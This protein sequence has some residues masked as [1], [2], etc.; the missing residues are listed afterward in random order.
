MPSRRL[1]TAHEWGVPAIPL[2]SLRRGMGSQQSA[3]QTLSYATAGAGSALAIAAATHLIAAAAVPFI[4]PAIAGAA[5]LAA[6]LIKNSGC[7]QTCIQTSEWANQAQAALK[8]NIDAY[9]A[10]PVPRSKENQQL[11]LQTFDSVWDTLV[12]MCG[13]PQWGDA[14]KAC[15]ADRQRGAC[16]WKATENSQWPGGVQLGEC[17]N[18]FAGFRDPIANDPNVGTAGASVS[19]LES[20]FTGGSGDSSSLLPALAIAGLLGLAVAL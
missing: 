18:W 15:I 5:L 19:D 6:Y 7:G 10:L 9:F 20:V 3:G 1:A 16:K 8:Q 4:G 11:A 14:G 13:D 17:F 2:P 12:H